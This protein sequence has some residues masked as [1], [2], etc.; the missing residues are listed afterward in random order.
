LNGFLSQ[1]HHLWVLIQYLFHIPVLLLPFQ[2]VAGAGKLL[3]HGLQRVFKQL[4]MVIQFRCLK[5]PQDKLDP[6]LFRQPVAFHG[7]D[8]SFLA[9]GCFRTPFNFWKGVQ[10]G[11]G[12]FERIDQFAFRGTGMRTDSF[13]HHGCPIR[14]KSLI[15]QGTKF[16]TVQGISEIC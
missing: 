15:L 8:K 1:R 11:G 5:I 4:K 14:G 10:E 6:H 13:N 16:S 3:Q 2:P 12:H 9:F 7:M